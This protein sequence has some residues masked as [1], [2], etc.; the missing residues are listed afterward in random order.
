MYIPKPGKTAFVAIGNSVI[1]SDLDAV[2]AATNAPG[3]QYYEPKWEDVV[4]LKST[5]QIIG[6]GYED[7]STTSGNP[8]LVFIT[9]DHGV[10][11]IERFADSSTDLITEESDPSDPVTLL[12][13]HIEQAIFYS[14]SSFIDF[15]FGTGYSLD[16]ISPAVNSVVSEILD[17][18]SPYLPPNFSSTRDSFTLRL[19]LLKTLIDYA[20]VNFLDAL[21]ILLPVIVEAL[22]KLEVAS[23]LWN[24]ID[25]QNP[26]AVKMKSMLKK[27]IIHNDLAQ[28]SV[29]QDTIRYFF[30]H[31]VGEILV[32][33]TELVETIFTSDVPLNVLLQLLVSTIHDA[34]HKNEVM[35]IFGISEIPPFRLWIFGS[36]LLVKAEEIFTQAYCSKHESFQALDTVS[37][38]N[39]LIQLTET[40]Y[41][42]VTS[43]IL[44][45]QQTNDDQLHD[46]L[47]W[48]NKRKGAW[49]DALITRG[50][51][52]EA[53]AI[54]QKY[55]D[56]YSVANILEKE[57][58]QTSP[59]YV[60]DKIDFF[61]NQYGYDFAAKLF[62]FYIQKDQVQRILIDCKPYKNFLEQ[63]FE[64]NPRKSSKVSWIYYLQVRGF[65][66][67]SNILMSLSSEKGN[68]NQENKEFNFS[69]AKLTAV[70]A[71]TEGASIDETSKLDEIAVE[72]E[73]NLVVIR[74]QNRLHHT[75]S[76]FV[77]GKKE[78]MTLEFF[79]DSF[80]NPRLE[81]N[82]L[83]TEIGAFFPKFVEQKALLKEQLICLLTSINPSPR[84]EHI[85]ADALKVSALFNNDST[86]HEQAS[87]IWKK[88][89]CLTDDWKSI[90][91]TEENSDE[92]NKMRV[93]E[94]TLFKTLK[95]VQDNKEIMKVL[96]DVLKAT[97][98]DHMSDGGRWNAMLEKLA[99]ECN[100]E[101][102]INT[103]R[104]EAK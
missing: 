15:N 44:F 3:F 1:L 78:L 35:F 96:D 16:V 71:K 65:K 20:R 23:N 67:A 54:A 13:S 19:N 39:Q 75:V 22:E 18:T 49:I 40:L 33:L 14:D 9:A 85:F 50:L 31:N 5:V 2:S 36:N 77:E 66:E 86:F 100:I 37:S 104:S 30:T 29:S 80:S 76:S 97:H 46:Y 94:T 10:V 103:V 63:Y 45:M 84:F 59:E 64:E 69:L 99:Q 25:S 79:L 82:E 83:V 43:A 21:Y 53:L 4:T 61:M 51:S 47:Q 41:F 102:W 87:E 55:H 7:Q 60:F 11:R 42:L 95:S 81:R 52:K 70:A 56:F 34:V 17:S 58:E 62:D 93:R 6:F 12:K 32:V 91:A 68:D 101:M 27:I 26:D 72:A 88:L 90:T 92:V 28:T 57:R 89:I 24:M 38:R 73:S 8:A 98:G 48:Y 74:T